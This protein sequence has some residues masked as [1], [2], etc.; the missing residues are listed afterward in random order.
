MI[1]FLGG[2]EVSLVGVVGLALLGIGFVVLSLSLV[3][4]YKN[5][6]KAKHIPGVWQFIDNAPCYIPILSP[7]HYM[8]CEYSLSKI[9]KEMGEKET[10]TFRVST[11]FGNRIYIH[12]REMLKE[13]HGQKMGLFPKPKEMY[14]ITE[15]FGEHIVSAPDND[16][17]KKHHRTVSPAFS[18]SNLEYMAMETSDVVDSITN[19]KWDPIIEKEGSVGIDV[20]HLFTNLTLDVL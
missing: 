10:G 12:D 8:G 19:F 13:L 3:L 4:I 9:V 6:Q 14:E 11:M 17:W 2:A 18:D 1:S 20:N 16:S 7:Y 15:I 5:Y